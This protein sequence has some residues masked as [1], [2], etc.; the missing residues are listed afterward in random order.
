MTMPVS[1]VF[2]SIQGEGPRAG[3]VCTFIRLGGCN[4]SCTFCDTPYTWDSSRYDL[5]REFSAMTADAIAHQVPDDVDEVVITGGEP[6]M[7]Q[8]KIAWADLLRLLHR[9]K[10]INIET[11]GTIC[12]NPTTRT[13]VHHYSISPKLPNAGQHKR[14]QRPEMAQW[15]TPMR[16][17]GTCLKFVVENEEDVRL[18]VEMSD[19]LG[20]RRDAVWMMP[21]GTSAERLLKRWREICEA[22]V[23]Y[24]VNATMRLHVL[25]W[26]NTRG[27]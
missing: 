12:P 7:H 16:Y 10:F 18:A 8:K 21:E 27:T 13:F 23:K 19:T 14:S 25:A 22:A 4:L 11:N 2:T 26:E 9:T 1:E 17:A 6:L 3:R 5:R 20:W 24:R 15:P